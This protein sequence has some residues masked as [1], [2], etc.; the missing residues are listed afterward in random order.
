M[1]AAQANQVAVVVEHRI[2]VGELCLRVD[3][4]VARVQL[5]PRGAG[6]EACVLTGGPLH[7][8]ACVV[9]AGG[10]DVTQHVLG[11]DAARLF[12]VLAPGVVN[13]QV[14]VVL[15]IVEEDVGHAQ[16]FTLVDVGGALHQV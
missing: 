16:L 11:G 5:Q 10:T 15:H 13:L 8:G 7:G 12:N 14:V 1:L 3:F 6:G 9:A 4:G 2:L